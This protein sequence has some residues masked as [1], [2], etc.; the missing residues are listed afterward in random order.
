MLE[1]CL[2][3]GLCYKTVLEKG[4][5]ARLSYKRAV[6]QDCLGQGLCCKTVLET[7]CVARLS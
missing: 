2:R 1:D 6:L 4:C 7:G 5:V 3:Q